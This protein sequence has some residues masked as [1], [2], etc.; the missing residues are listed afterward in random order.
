L[1][2]EA[3]PTPPPAHNDLCDRGI[4]HLAFTV[5]NVEAAWETLRREGSIT[6]SDPVTAP[7]G[8]ARLFFARDPEG[9]LME[10][11]QVLDTS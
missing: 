2:D 11:V 4:R 3:H 7:D 1:K 10:I 6:L 5:A 9:N 8:K